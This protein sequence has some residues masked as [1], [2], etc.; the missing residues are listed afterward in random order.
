MGEI[1]NNFIINQTQKIRFILI[2][3]INLNY[4][5][6]C[7]NLNSKGFYFFG[8]K[9]LLT[10]GINFLKF[11]K[12]IL[13]SLAIKRLSYQLRFKQPMQMVELKLN[14]TIDENR[15]FINSLDRSVNH[16]LFPKY[17]H[18]PV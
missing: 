17:S 16:P 2:H 5:L 12:L 9:T 13:H 11:V 6:T 18:I 8:L 1:S 10:E 4:E 14:F 7:Q 3:S 15:Q